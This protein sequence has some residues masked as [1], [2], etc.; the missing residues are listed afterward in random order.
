MAASPSMAAP[1]DGLMIV[2]DA[3]KNIS[4]SINEARFFHQSILLP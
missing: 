2:N 3:S 4:V 1:G